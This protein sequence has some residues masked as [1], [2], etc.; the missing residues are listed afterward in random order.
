MTLTLNLYINQIVTKE[1][2]K[3]QLKKM[4]YI[5]ASKNFKINE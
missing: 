5:I 3:I 1:K 2:D 4:F